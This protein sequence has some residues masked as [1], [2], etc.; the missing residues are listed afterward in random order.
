M[1]ENMEKFFPELNPSNKKKL[2]IHLQPASKLKHST[3]QALNEVC[4]L[5]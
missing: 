1:P 5:T 2:E 4:S 3:F